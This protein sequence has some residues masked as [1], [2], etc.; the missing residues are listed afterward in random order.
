M[1]VVDR[2]QMRRVRTSALSLVAFAVFLRHPERSHHGYI[3]LSV[4]KEDEH[5]DES[6]KLP[7]TVHRNGEQ[8]RPKL[9]L[10]HSM[11]ACKL[12]LLTP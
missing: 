10:E 3:G 9:L 5:V 4:R 8:Y 12:A 1:V 2:F 7:D 11:N 6:R